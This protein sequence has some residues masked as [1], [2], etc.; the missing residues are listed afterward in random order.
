MSFEDLTAESTL[1]FVSKAKSMA[2]EIRANLGLG[3]PDKRP[4]RKL[5]ELLQE[6]SRVK[7]TYS[8]PVGLPEAREAVA[9]WLSGRYGLDISPKEVM[10]TPSGKAALF[11]ALGYASTRY[12]SSLLFDPTYYSYEPVLRAFGVKVKKVKMLRDENSYVFPEVELGKEIVVLNSPSNPTGAV[13]GARTLEYVDEALRTGALIVSDEVYD[14]F[15]YG[16]RHVS[17]L[18]HERWRDAAIFIYS[19]SKVLCVPGWRLGAV[20]AREE[21]IE[22]LAA[23]ASNVYG[24]ACKWEQIA[25]AEYLKNYKND[26]E[27]HIKN[28]VEDYSRRREF[29]LK[30]LKEVASFPGV[31]EGTFYAF[32]EFPKDADEL[33]LELA[34]RGVI[35]VPGT[36]FSE[37][38]G[39]RSLRLSFSAPLEELRVG[40][41]TIKEVLG[42]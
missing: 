3:E 36:V 7:P 20:V 19:F 32:P 40:L 37:A 15:V 26:L 8:P 14:V 12:S 18:E 35:A 38:F 11:L 1:K 2:R 34:K 9:E 22:K 33:A 21:V 25:L 10:I 24:C 27:N 41:E 42:S 16:R 39:K 6:A 30:E 5:V 31:G 17:V 28:M 29:L 23:A 13:L 4:P